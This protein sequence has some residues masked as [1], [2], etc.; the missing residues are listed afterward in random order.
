MW[1]QVEVQTTDNAMA[2]FIRP[3]PKLFMS[4]HNIFNIQWNG[5]W[6]VSL[7]ICDRHQ[8]CNTA[9]YNIYFG[10]FFTTGT[11]QDPECAA[12]ATSQD[13]QHILRINGITIGNCGFD[14]PSAADYLVIQKGAGI[15]LTYEVTILGIT[16]TSE[17]S[18][19]LPKTAHAGRIFAEKKQKPLM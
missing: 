3:D 5:T 9:S 7:K 19:L 10:P 17:I 11:A 16:L 14:V 12:S 2:L 18:T 6:P 8:A 4:D 1:D 15:F 13:L